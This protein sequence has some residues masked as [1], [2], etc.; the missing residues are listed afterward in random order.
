MKLIKICENIK[1]KIDY[2]CFP[3]I[4][5]Q[6][7]L[8]N[9]E[10]DDFFLNLNCFFGFIIQN[11]KTHDLRM[12]TDSVNSWHIYY[13]LETNKAEFFP[14]M[15]FYSNTINSQALKCYLKYRYIMSPLFFFKNTQCCSNWSVTLLSNG[16]AKIIKSK[17]FEFNK[18]DILDSEFKEFIEYSFSNFIQKLDL[19]KAGVFLSG[20]MDSTGVA[21]L[22]KKN[23]SDLKALST[24][25]PGYSFDENTFLES[26]I[27]KLSIDNKKFTMDYL[28]Y[29]KFWEKMPYIYPQP[30]STHTGACFYKMAENSIEK[31]IFS[32]FGGDEIFGGDIKYNSSIIIDDYSN[33]VS[34][35]S[36]LRF[37]NGYEKF[38][39]FI[40]FYKNDLDFGLKD[41]NIDFLSSMI[42]FNLT[43]WQGDYENYTLNNIF[44]SLNKNHIAPMLIPSFVKKINNVKNKYKIN[45]SIT[46]YIYRKW[47]EKHT[48]SDFAYRQSQGFSVP[49][50]KMFN[51][52]LKDYMEEKIYN[53]TKRK[54]F[55]CFFSKNEI[56][57]NIKRLNNGENKYN[58]ILI[59]IILEIFLTE[60]EKNKGSLY[61]S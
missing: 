49:L 37:E 12:I 22:L 40:E 35:N 25:F 45:G 33:Y 47:I 38:N 59:I 39:S 56:Y 32:G 2:I 58:S 4:N 30:V 18:D 60:Y 52:E 14:D 20:G 19:K 61:I 53:F 16:K 28:D 57:D 48:N 15:N 24:I 1:Y 6:D 42:N 10:N 23:I 3:D 41:N 26:I 36:N 31:T 27:K 44:N 29:I 11:K 54:E 17:Q 51:N 7:I 46:R 34:K 43:K 50:N 13:N 9:I 8:D 55:N 5:T 21:I